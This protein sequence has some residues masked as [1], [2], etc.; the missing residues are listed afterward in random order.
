MSGE[1]AE[2]SNSR[3]AAAEN[4]SEVLMPPPAARAK[5]CPQRAHSTTEPALA[6]GSV[7]TNPQSVHPTR[8]VACCIRGDN[9][10]LQQKYNQP[11]G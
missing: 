9:T 10:G 11:C 4:A 3:R 8:L 7:C 1:S 6:G 5:P 2:G